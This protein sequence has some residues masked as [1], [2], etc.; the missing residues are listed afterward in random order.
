MEVVFTIFILIFSSSS[1]SKPFNSNV[2]EASDADEN[3]KFAIL[4]FII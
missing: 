4:F 2:G 1:Q 3:S